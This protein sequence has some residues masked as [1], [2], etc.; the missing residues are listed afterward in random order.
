MTHL[1]KEAKALEASA[2]VR[3][4]MRMAINEDLGRAGDTTTLS[5]VA[6]D[7]RGEG[8]IIARQDCQVSGTRVAESIFQAF[9]GEVVCDIKVF[10]G[11]SA[12]KG[13]VIIHISGLY[14]AMLTAERT[15]LNFMQRMSGVATLTA[16]FMKQ[17][18][19]IDVDLLDTRK[20]L[21]GYRALDKFSVLCGG[22]TNHRMGFMIK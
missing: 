22:G 15:A 19:G 21:P 6:A 3:T 7:A 4:I 5:V 9:D 16:Q 18:E 11:Q 2:P 13:D 20:T 1:D 12:Q 17:V 10:D 8:D 14:G